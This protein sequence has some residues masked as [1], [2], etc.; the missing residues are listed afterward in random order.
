MQKVA[1]PPRSDLAHNG[2]I[3]LRVVG[4]LTGAI[5]AVD[6]GLAALAR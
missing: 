2:A 1:R 3:C 6:V 5:A 4:L